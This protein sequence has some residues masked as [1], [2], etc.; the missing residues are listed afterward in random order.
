MYLLFQAECEINFHTCGPLFQKW[1]SIVYTN[2]GIKRHG[3]RSAIYVSFCTIRR[4]KLE[5]I[6]KKSSS[7]NVIQ[8]VESDETIKFVC[9]NL[10]VL[11][12]NILKL[13]E[14]NIVKYHNN[15]VQVLIPST[16]NFIKQGITSTI[17]FT[18]LLK[19][20]ENL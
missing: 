19:L 10:I 14:F 13:Q 9:W 7:T 2:L 16:H 20:W 4:Q 3:D 8:A 11:L 1:I 5:I 12:K 15:K 6:F 17:P 18:E